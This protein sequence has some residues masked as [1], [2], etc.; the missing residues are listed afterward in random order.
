MEFALQIALAVIIGLL[1][2]ITYGLRRMFL[3]EERI[4]G[5]ELDI[6]KLLSSKKR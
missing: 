6:Q 5:I 2:G 3:L 4:A 1:V